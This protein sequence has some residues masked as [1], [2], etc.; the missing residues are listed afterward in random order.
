M[1]P[2]PAAGLQDDLFPSRGPMAGPT[3][4][5]YNSGWMRF[6]KPFF[7]PLAAFALIAA[8]TLGL[9]ALP[10]PWPGWKLASCYPGCFCEAFRAGGVVQPLSS[11]SNLFY[12]LAGLLILGA[13]GAAWFPARAN[14]M[15]RHRGYA[16]G[17]GLAVIFIGVTSF[18]FHVSLTHAGRW[19]DYLG[20]YA[21]AGYALLYGLARLRRWSDAAFLAAYFLLL[22]ACGGL[23]FAAPGMRRPLLGGLIVGVTAVEVGAH[24]I[25]RLLR[26]RTRY[27][28]GALGCFL[29]AYALNMADESGAICAPASLWQWHVVWHFLTAVSAGMLFLYYYSE[30]GE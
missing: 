25:R 3:H 28:L 12:L 23:W 8:M 29:A 7:L 16:A 5:G 10:F 6:L 30:D 26:I 15:T 21:F 27:L 1:I 20:M 13:S 9:E 19:L 11:Y 2:R 22:A 18:F 4:P 14:R 24:W 17:F